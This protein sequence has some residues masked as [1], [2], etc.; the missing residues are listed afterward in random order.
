MFESVKR[1]FN[2]PSAGPSVLEVRSS[3]ELQRNTLLVIGDRTYQV[4]RLLR[5]GGDG[6]THEAKRLR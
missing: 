2:R 5:A 1:L 6:Y 4:T 3:V